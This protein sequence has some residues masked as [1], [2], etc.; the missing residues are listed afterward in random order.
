M[1]AALPGPEGHVVGLRLFQ[2]L[3]QVQIAEEMGCAQIHVSR[4][5]RRA[6]GRLRC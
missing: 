6:L 3:S 4:L 5:L 2:E 1:P